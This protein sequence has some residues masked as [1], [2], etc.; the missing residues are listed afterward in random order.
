MTELA[1][2]A[3]LMLGLVGFVVWA[4]RMARQAERSK[5]IGDLLNEEKEANEHLRIRNEILRTTPVA[6]SARR[7]QDQWSRSPEQLLR[8]DIDHLDASG[9][10][11]DGLDVK[12]DR[13]SQQDAH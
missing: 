5:S 2:I 7:V 4:S 3:G 8:D 1:L 6:G 11:A 9:G 13:N 10:P 12:S